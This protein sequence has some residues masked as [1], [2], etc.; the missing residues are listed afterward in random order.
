MSNPAKDALGAPH[1]ANPGHGTKVS[2]YIES[3][4]PR[5]CGTCKYLERGVL[6]DNHIVLR[7]S[8]IPKDQKTGLRIVDPV[9]G[10]CNQWISSK[11]AE[12]RAAK[13]EFEKAMHQAV[14]DAPKVI[15]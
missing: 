9:Y 6:C 2:G 13:G 1:I 7:D 8:Q 15:I 10:C 3:A 11:D 12:E 5:A 4:V 14:P